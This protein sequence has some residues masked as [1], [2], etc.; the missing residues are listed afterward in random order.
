M[1]D[2]FKLYEQRRDIGS[3]GYYP[4]AIT[5]TAHPGRYF[6]GTDLHDGYK[7][8]LAKLE[9]FR[10]N[11]QD[12]FSDEYTLFRD[13]VLGERI[14]KDPSARYAK[15]AKYEEAAENLRTVAQENG[16]QVPVIPEPVE[17][18]KFPAEPDG[19]YGTVVKFA[20]HLPLVRFGYGPK[21]K[22]TGRSREYTWADLFTAGPLR[23]MKNAD[24]TVLYAG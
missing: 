18:P 21:W 7:D 5:N 22:F 24:Y 8:G 1:E 15:Y 13:A 23:Y 2:Q 20:G 19:G 6:Q 9:H 12:W 11:P 10:E 3:Y 4:W 17:A 14:D 16:F